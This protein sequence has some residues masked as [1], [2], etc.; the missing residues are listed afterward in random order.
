MKSFSVSYRKNGLI[1]EGVMTAESGLH[2]RNMVSEMGYLFI[3]AIL[4][5]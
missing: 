3:S 2:I 4:V 1:V 5:K